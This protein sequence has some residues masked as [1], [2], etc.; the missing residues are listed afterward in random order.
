MPSL[1]GFKGSVVSSLPP[2]LYA[3]IYTLY[4]ALSDDRDALVIKRCPDGKGWRLVNNNR[5]WEFVVPDPKLA[6]RLDAH[7]Y[8]RNKKFNIYTLKGFVTVEPGDVVVDVGSFVGEFSVAAAELASSV[9]AI[10]ADARNY[11]LLRRNVDRFVNV[12]IIQAAV[13]NRS[14]NES[15]H[16]GADPTEHS[17][18][19]IDS[20]GEREQRTV[21][22][23]RLDEI[24]SECGIDRIDYLKVDAEGAEPEVLAGTGDLDIEKLAVSVTPERYGESPAAAVRE[25]L[26]DR[27][28]ETRHHDGVLFGKKA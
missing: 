11:E 12:E 19:G 22:T 21:Y 8:E 5:G 26:E 14:G 25:L 3:R 20:G 2:T 28:Y 27:R 13:W 23:K 4:S 6:P 1:G 18:L 7:R 15:F 17:L 24:A 16:L 9:V 10:E